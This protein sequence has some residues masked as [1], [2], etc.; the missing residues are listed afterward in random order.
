MDGSETKKSTG[1]LLGPVDD[2]SFV[3][4]QHNLEITQGRPS[5][6]T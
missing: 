6:F 4:Q 5:S 3:L 1:Q 2:R